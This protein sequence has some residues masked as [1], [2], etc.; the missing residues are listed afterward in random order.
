MAAMT[1]IRSSSPL[2]LRR[3]SETKPLMTTTS[4]G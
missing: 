4:W 1:Q 3:I 2:P